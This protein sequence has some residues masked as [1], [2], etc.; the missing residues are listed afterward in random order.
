MHRATTLGL[1]LG[2]VAVGLALF[3]FGCW[4]LVRP[5]L[6]IFGEHL[7]D[8]W[9]YQSRDAHRFTAMSM[10]EGSLKYHYSLVSLA[11]DE[12]VRNGA[13]YTNWGYGV[14][15]LQMPFHAIARH[16][17]SVPAAGFFPDRAIFFFY[18]ALT[19]A[20]LWA[21]LDRFLAT[22]ERW[23]GSSRLRRHALSWTAACFILC[24]GLYPSISAH[25]H[26]YDE[27]I[28]YFVMAE[29]VAM[30]AYACLLGSSRWAPVVSLAAAAGMG[31]LIR[32]TGAI[33]LAMWAALVVLERPSRRTAIVFLGAAA[34][35]V[36]FWMYTNWVRSGSPWSLGFQNA[37]P[38]AEHAGQQRFGS[39]CVDNWEHTKL[40]TKYIFKALFFVAVTSAE[41]PAFLHQCQFALERRTPSDSPIEP[42][43]GPVVLVFLVWTLLDL[44]FRRQ[45]KIALYLPH[46]TIAVIFAMYVYAGVGMAW[47]YVGDFLPL[48]F[49]AAIQYVRSFPPMASSVVGWPLAAVLFIG[50]YGNYRLHVQPTKTQMENID[51]SRIPHMME[52]FRS[53]RSG[54]GDKSLP[55]K[56][57][58]GGSLE[59]P[60][61]N[62]PWRTN[63]AGWEHDCVVWTITE[64]FLGVPAKHDDSYV[65]RFETKG[66]VPTSLP[67]YV[68]GRYYTAHK[69]GDTYE[70][71]VQI[72]YD[73]LTSPTILVSIEWQHKV[74]PVPGKLLAISIE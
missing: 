7:K 9:T 44:V 34:P 59:W 14:P 57:Q 61:F 25:F 26:V 53:T 32:P 74:G 65:V 17:R 15:L 70:A 8:I 64:V 46:A 40:F 51:A 52:D 22:R 31:L 72:P 42:Y 41:A 71:K 11:G 54:Q 48:V 27:T 6:H 60:H 73:S 4:V 39:I 43:L 33:F 18:L 36:F 35:F 23:P 56:V 38:G 58:C 1:R 3:V 62:V 37:L 13:G 66:M 20:V 49:L 2:R 28:A 5:G 30:S 63:W 69:V 55:S 67:V 47:R 12:Q 68:N 45:R 19:A 50:A 29:L 24:A 21:G 16:M 10:L